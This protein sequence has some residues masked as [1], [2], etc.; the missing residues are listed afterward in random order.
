M[1]DQED[2]KLPGVASFPI[3]CIETEARLL[4]K[5]GR[6]AV[7]LLTAAQEDSLAVVTIDREGMLEVGT[8]ILQL[9]SIIR[10]KK[11]VS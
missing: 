11:L 4:D 3:S 5:L 8:A 6:H 10:N 2:L 7:L 9:L 1:N